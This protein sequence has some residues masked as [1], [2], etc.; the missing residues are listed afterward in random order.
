MALEVF[1]DYKRLG[2]DEWLRMTIPPHEYFDPHEEILGMDS[3]PRHNHAID[4][5]KGIPKVC[6]EATRLTIADTKVGK[7]GT[8]TE[9]FWN[10][11]ENR[12]IER[13]DLFGQDDW[14][15]IIDVVVT[16]D[17]YVSECLRIGRVRGTIQVLSHVF[18]ERRTDGSEKERVMY[19]REQ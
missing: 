12:V 7:S 3:V 17:P 6:V 8:I 18:I 9:T 14:E 1:I 15:L 11:G 19:S 10:G 5:L 13:R 2:S 4:Y 16:D